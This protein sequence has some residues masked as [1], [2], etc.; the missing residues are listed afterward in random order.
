MPIPPLPSPS[1]PS[2][3]SL[4]H[5][6]LQ[7]HGGERRPPPEQGLCSP[8][9]RVGLGEHRHLL[10][11]THRQ[12][13]TEEL[14]GGRDWPYVPSE[15][16]SEGKRARRAKS[17]VQAWGSWAIVRRE[18]DNPWPGGHRPFPTLS[19]LPSA[20]TGAQFR[21]G[22]SMVEEGTGARHAAQVPT[23]PRP[24][25]PPS[26]ESP[27]RTAAAGR[28]PPVPSFSPFPR[29]RAL[30]L[31]AETTSATTVTGAGQGAGGCHRRSRSTPPGQLP[32]FWQLTPQ[33]SPRASCE[34]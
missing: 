25:L 11:S 2:A 9:A 23:G 29:R 33:T 19:P 34:G 27:G 3:A 4:Q 8:S 7:A 32:G 15:E 16:E 13:G 17:E 20:P 22:P 28:Y 14:W 24:G 12:T 21:L 26:P 1:V 18:A 30:Q 5:H 10:F 6:P 31:G